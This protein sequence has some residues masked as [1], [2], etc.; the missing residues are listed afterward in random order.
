MYAQTPQ[1]QDSARIKKLRGKALIE[2]NGNSLF[3]NN[4]AA[5]KYFKLALWELARRT[6]TSLN[7]FD[8]E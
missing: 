5:C 3:K 1:D 4:N 6:L 7:L 2:E 8:L